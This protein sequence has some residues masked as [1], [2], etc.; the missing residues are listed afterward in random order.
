MAQA[1]LRLPGRQHRAVGLS[2]AHRHRAG[3]SLLARWAGVRGAQAAGRC[4]GV[5][6]SLGSASVVVIGCRT[7]PCWRGSRSALAAGVGAVLAPS[8]SAPGSGSSPSPAAASTRPP[9]SRAA[10]RGARSH[11]GAGGVCARLR[12]A[13][14]WQWVSS[15]RG[16]SYGGVPGLAAACSV[17]PALAL[18]P[19]GS[20]M[21]G[22][23]RRGARPARDA[24]SRLAFSAWHRCGRGLVP[25]N[26]G[27]QRHAGAR[28][29]EPAALGRDDHG[30]AQIDQQ[31]MPRRTGLLLVHR[32][33]PAVAARTRDGDA[34]SERDETAALAPQ[35]P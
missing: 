2:R 28:P 15:P 7:G 24:P 3:R 32:Q 29:I 9:R 19:G 31:F 5:F 27:Q 34:R 20:P 16:G 30:A 4:G 8:R 25:R 23:Q 10:T 1:L 26:G 6:S 11:A 33:T 17:V 18:Q 35:P 21:A 12:S 13:P 22:V 14:A